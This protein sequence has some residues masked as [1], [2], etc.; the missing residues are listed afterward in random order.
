LL[1]LGD[2]AKR[3]NLELLGEPN[4]ELEGIAPLATAKAEQLSFVAKATH[5]SEADTTQAGA[6]ILRPEWAERWSG[7]GLLSED[8]YLSF[9][10]VTH[11]FDERPVA[12]EGVHGSAVVHETVVLGADVSVGANAVLE[13]GVVIGDGAT[14]GAGVYVGHHT[15]IGSSTRLYPNAVLYHRVV[16]GAHCIIHSNATIGSDGFG[17][18]PSA[19]GWVKILQQGGVR[20][21]DRVEIEVRWKIRLSK[22]TLFWIIWCTSLITYVLVSGRR[23]LLAVVSAAVRLLAK[24]ALLQVWSVLPTTLLLPTMSTSMGREELASL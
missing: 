1:K 20:I 7:A 8:P 18:A 15:Q 6:L 9:A 13:E 5:W 17:F 4:I 23:L 11:L 21:G 16:V 12:P 24:T 22:I 10:Q 14:I 19:E 3:L 2:I